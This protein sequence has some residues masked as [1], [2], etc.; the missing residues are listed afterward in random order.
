MERKLQFIPAQLKVIEHVRPKYS[1]RRCEK[2]NTSVKIKVAPLPASPIPKSIATASLLTQIITSKFQYALPLYRQES[3]FKQYGIELSRK[4]MSVWMMKSA[5]LLKPI[6][7]RLIEIQLQQAAIHADETPLNVIMEDKAKC[8]MWVCCSLF[9]TLPAFPPSMEVYC[10][11]F[12]TLPAFPPSMEVYCCGA[13]SPPKADTPPNKI[14]PPDKAS[15]PRIVIYDYQNS[16][17]GQCPI[18]Y[19]RGFDGYLQVDGYVGYEQ[20]DALLVGCMAHAR[21]KFKDAKTAQPKSKS[22]KADIALGMIQKLYRIEAQI[23]TETISETLRIRQEQAKPILDEFKCWLDK[24]ALQVVPKSVLG[25]AIGYTLG[26][27][28]KLIRYIED[29]QLNIDNNRAERAIKPF[30]IG[31]KNWLF[32]YTQNGAQASAVLYSLIE[33]AKANGLVPFDYLCRLLTEL[34]ED[35]QDL[36]LL[37]PWNS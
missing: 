21:R 31:R 32:S 8:Y 13:D 15:I 17:A 3:L 12:Q 5:T 1:C 24:S 14:L 23:K 19:L 29:G 2:Q 10:S 16:R 28:P 18:N 26:Q 34:P 37:M 6:Y 30:V 27:W 7:D 25:I 33:T 22:G 9:Q 4:T 35:P 11:L 36:D 20:T